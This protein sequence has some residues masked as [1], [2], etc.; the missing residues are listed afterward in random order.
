[1][2]R[3][4]GVDHRQ[5]GLP[6]PQQ[7]HLA[8][9]VEIVLVDHGEARPMA[10]ERGRPLGFRRREHR[11]EER[12]G[13]ARV[14]A[15]RRRRT[16]RRAARTAAAPPRAW[17]RTG[18]NRPARTGPSGP[19]RWASHAAACSD[20]GV[21]RSGIRGEFVAVMPGRSGLAIDVERLA[22][23]ALPREDRARCEAQRR[24]RRRSS[25]RAS[26][27]SASPSAWRRAARP[28]RPPRRRFRRAPAPG[29]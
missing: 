15:R 3:A 6:H 4:R 14:R 2:P 7:A 28:P 5:R 12:D 23:R 9:V 16:A 8:Q 20:D 1:M 25:S 27:T 21:C 13:V 24:H 29:P 18:G 19:T 11:I 10:V 17:D 22:R 26:A